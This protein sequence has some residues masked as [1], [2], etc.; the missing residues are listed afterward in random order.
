[1]W[2]AS[3][4]GGRVRPTDAEAIPLPPDALA[5]ARAPSSRIDP[6]VASFA[7]GAFALADP[8]NTLPLSAIVRGSPLFA[9][10]VDDDIPANAPSGPNPASC[11]TSASFK[12]FRNGLYCGR[13]QIVSLSSSFVAFARVLARARP[14][15]ASPNRSPL[16]RARVAFAR[17]SSPLIASTPRTNAF[18]DA[19]CRGSAA[20]MPPPRHSATRIARESLDDRRDAR[21]WVGRRLERGERW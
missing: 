19:K 18:R 8:P 21:P 1:M 20:E 5:D 14:P 11:S 3:G 17:T 6:R 4:C 16:A 7:A 10:A 15:C 9:V 2:G 12:S 13:S